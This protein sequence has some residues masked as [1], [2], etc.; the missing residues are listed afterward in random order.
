MLDNY[1]R[2]YNVEFGSRLMSINVEN[3]HQF[4][5]SNFE[6]INEGKSQS[7]SQIVA[8]SSN[9]GLR[10]DLGHDLDRLTKGNQHQVNL[11]P[12]PSLT[13]MVQPNKIDYSERCKYDL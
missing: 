10:K 4:I 9:K 13:V 2:K 6:I 11:S 1:S 5:D 3:Q 12:Q 8:K 7:T